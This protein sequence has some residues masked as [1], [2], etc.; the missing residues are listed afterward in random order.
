MYR[1]ICLDNLMAS[2]KIRSFQS[3]DLQAC[4]DL[5]VRGHRENLEPEIY[6]DYVLQD[7]LSDIQNRYMNQPNSHWWV[8]VDTDTNAVIGQVALLPL[9]IDSRSYYE[10]LPVDKRDSAGELL[11]LS[12]HSDYQRKGIGRQ[13]LNRLFNFARECGYKEIYLTTGMRMKKALA[14]YATNGFIAAEIGRCLMD[15]TRLKTFDDSKM[16]FSLEKDT[17]LFPTDTAMPDED[18]ERMNDWSKEALFYYY[19]WFRKSIV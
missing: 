9:K 13:L 5:F 4:R 3:S 1:L 10:S 6:I 14:F 11:R 12:V 15:L 2:I 17:I 7:D 19:R 8:A 16:V 18:R